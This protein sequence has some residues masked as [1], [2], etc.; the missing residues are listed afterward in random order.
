M[1]NVSR[2]SAIASSQDVHQFRDLPALLLLVAAR[3]RMFDAMGNVIPQNLLLDF[4][5]SG[6]NSGNLR[7]DVDTVPVLF[8][9][10]RKSTDLTFDAAKAFQR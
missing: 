7:Y 4:P 1:A 3:D 5:Q 8:K 9:H 6:T 2:H 10:F